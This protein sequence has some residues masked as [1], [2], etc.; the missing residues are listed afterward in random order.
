MGLWG[1]VGLASAIHNGAGN[2]LSIN[3]LTHGVSFPGVMEYLDD[4]HRVAITETKNMLKNTDSVVNA[5]R[6]GW[7]GA[8][9]TNFEKNLDSAVNAVATALDTL[10]QGL[11]SLFTDLTETM[12]LQDEKLV[13]VE[14]IIN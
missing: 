14:D 7:Q 1:P 10:Q 5:L 12:A 9:E 8:A 3:E 2:N 11:D 4:I 6:A 13:E